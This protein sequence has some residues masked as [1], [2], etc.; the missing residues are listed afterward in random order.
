MRDVVHTVWGLLL[1][2]TQFTR[3][4]NPQPYPKSTLMYKRQMIHQGLPMLTVSGHLLSTLLALRPKVKQYSLR[5]YL[6]FVVGFLVEGKW[7]VWF[8]NAVLK[9][10]LCHPFLSIGIPSDCYAAN[11]HYFSQINLLKIKNT[12]LAERSLMCTETT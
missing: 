12:F 7:T 1:K 3:L 2:V 8:I 10:K 9:L 6:H 11:H 5:I 4:E